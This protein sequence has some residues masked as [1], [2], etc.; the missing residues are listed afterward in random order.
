MNNDETIKDFYRIIHLYNENILRPV[1]MIHTLISLFGQNSDVVNFMK[2][3]VN[4][5]N[6]IKESSSPS[7]S[8]SSLGGPS[9]ASGRPTG[10]GMT[11][12]SNAADRHGSASDY[13]NE[14]DINSCL[15]FQRSYRQLPTAFKQPKCSGRDELCREVSYACFVK[16][17]KFLNHCFRTVLSH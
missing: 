14:V 13:R 10:G 7:F 1:E 5:S 2:R 12:G 9:A 8:L 6:V 11:L 3:A 16:R 15:N 4:Y 17:K